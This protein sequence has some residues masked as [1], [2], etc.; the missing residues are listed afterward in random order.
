[1]SKKQDKE[2]IKLSEKLAL[3]F[4]KKWLVSGIQTFLIVAILI[5]GYIS[6]NL[7]VRQ[8]DLPQI[9]VTDFET[10]KWYLD[11][12][13]LRGSINDFELNLTFEELEALIE[14]LN[15]HEKHVDE[16]INFDKYIIPFH[17]I[18]KW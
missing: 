15:K 4:R 2:K 8:L 14:H 11:S 1:M 16:H 10:K 13:P 3:N 7:F 6:L 9:D 18:G 12:R 17:K 5:M